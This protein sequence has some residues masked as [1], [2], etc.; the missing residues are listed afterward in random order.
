MPHVRPDGLDFCVAAA[1]VYPPRQQ[2]CLVDHKKLGCWL[3][4]GG[5][6]G[7]ENPKETTDEALEK[8]LR[9][10]TGLIVGETCKI[11]QLGS[12][13]G[14]SF[15][16]RWKVWNRFS[17]EQNPH[18]ARQLFVPWAVEI[19]DFPPLPGHVHLAF[20]YLV[21]A[22]TPELKLEEAHR[23]IRWFSHNDLEALDNVS[24][25][26]RW[27]AHEAIELLKH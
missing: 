26:I 6:V 7:D 8:E 25:P 13:R 15:L 9:E 11:V 21:E 27:Y 10:E 5:H 19:H 18:H 17:P 12:T 23:A 20:V 24:G 4:P 22:L 2:V 1:I 16:D 14:K 3:L